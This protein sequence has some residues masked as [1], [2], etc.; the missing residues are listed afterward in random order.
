M[1]SL[2]SLARALGVVRFIRDRWVHSTEPWGSLGYSG[3]VGFTRARPVGMRVHPVSL[4]SLARAL[5][6]DGFIR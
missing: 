2:G 6:V 3:V 4:V 1:E 5:C